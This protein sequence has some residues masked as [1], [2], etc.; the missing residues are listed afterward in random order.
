MKAGLPVFLIFPFTSN[1]GSAPQKDMYDKKSQD[2][3][4]WFVTGPITL[5]AAAVLQSDLTSIRNDP[6]KVSACGWRII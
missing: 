4:E 5:Q 1:S 2:G 3:F 6:F